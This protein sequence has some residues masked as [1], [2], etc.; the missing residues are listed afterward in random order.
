MPHEREH[1]TAHC[2]ALR[3]LLNT[4]SNPFLALS[5]RR[6]HPVFVDS[7]VL[8]FFLLSREICEYRPNHVYYALLFSN[9]KPV[10]INNCLLFATGAEAVVK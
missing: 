6:P 9:L 7:Y 2:L 1:R 5:H 4:A 3:L 8:F 10:A